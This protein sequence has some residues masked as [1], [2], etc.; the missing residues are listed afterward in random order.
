MNKPITSQLSPDGGVQWMHTVGYGRLDE[1]LCFDCAEPFSRCQCQE[2]CAACEG[3][4]CQVCNF[5]GRVVEGVP[6]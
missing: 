4:G 3:K 2:R 6:G 5:Y 1:D